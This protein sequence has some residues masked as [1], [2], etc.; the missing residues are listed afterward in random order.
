MSAVVYDVSGTDGIAA[1]LRA[2]VDQPVLADVEIPRARAAAPRVRLAVREIFLEA[3][4]ARIEVLGD[5]PRAADLAR[6][7]VEYRTLGLTERLQAAAAV[8]DDADRRR[9]AQLARA[10]VDRPRVLGIL[11]AAA[12]H[13]VDVDVERG[14]FRHPLQLLVEQP[15]ALLRDFVRLDVVDADLQEVEAGVVQRDDALRRHQVAVGDQPRHHALLADPADQL[16]EIGMEH[17]LAAAER[18]HGRLEA[19]Q[20]IDPFDHRLRRHRVRHFVVLV[21]VAAVDVAAADR[22]DVDEKRMRGVRQPVCEFPDGPS[23]PGRASL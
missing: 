9:E 11:D 15:Q 14:V 18:H 17:R 22:N 13:R 5:L 10:T 16:V 2:V 20:M 3:A 23:L 6:H 4:N 21:A 1:L 7:A 8:V 19:R 12:E